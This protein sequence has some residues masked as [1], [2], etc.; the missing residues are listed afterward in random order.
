MSFWRRR[1]VIVTGGAGM[2]GSFL[3]PALR[4]A[5]AMVT[6]LDNFS[7]GQNKVDG[8]SYI[9]ADTGNVNVCLRAFRDAF[10]VL[11]LA[12]SVGGV[13][14]NLSNQAFQFCENLRLQAAP[15]L[16]IAQMPPYARPE[17]F[18][19]VSSVCVYSKSYNAPAKE[20]FGHFGEPEQA[21]AGY[22]W[23]K[24]M[25]EKVA[26]WALQNIH[27]SVVRPTNMYGERDYF[28]DRAHVIPALIKK[29]VKQDKVVVFGRNQSR[30]FL[31]AEDGARAMM[32]VAEHGG[33]GQV[34]NLGTGGET[35]VTVADLASVISVLT[36][37]NA[38]IE[39]DA[40]AA[41]GDAHRFTDVSKLEG[42]GWKYRIPLEDGIDRVIRWYHIN[43]GCGQA[44]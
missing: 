32:F 1:K 30:E 3:C 36:G 26:S 18:L 13:Y 14:F 22:S 38:R 7:R 44:F 8:V 31:H 10:A 24:R 42:L 33:H 41:T 4:D 20:P 40:V 23:A 25:G 27:Y 2:V 29:F 16:A 9:K 17:R 35:K 34:Y 39:Y 12:A 43:H 28:D 6:V 19:Q 11:N 15:A 21:N 37:S 5:G